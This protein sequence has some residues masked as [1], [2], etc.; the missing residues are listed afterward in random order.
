MECCR[1][2][3]EHQG[4]YGIAFKVYYHILEL[5]LLVHNNI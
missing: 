2:V 3:P 4:E 1:L 5:I